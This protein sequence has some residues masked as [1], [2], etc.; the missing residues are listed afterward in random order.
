MDVLPDKLMNKH[1]GPRAS[2]S[3]EAFGSWNQKGAFKAIVI[4][5]SDEI[6][7][8]LRKKLDMAFMFSALDETEKNVVI[9]AMSELKAVINDVII[10]EGAEGDCLFIV[11]SGNLICTKIFP[12]STEPTFLK[13]Y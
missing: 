13:R 5:K 9:D 6:K 7:T 8:A 11:D 12:G 3:A 10:K 1:R 4:P 2:V